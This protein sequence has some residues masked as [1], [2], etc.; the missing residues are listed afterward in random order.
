M[1]HTQIQN[2]TENVYRYHKEFGTPAKDLFLRPMPVT[3]PS[4]SICCSSKTTW[5]FLIQ[6]MTLRR[7]QESLWTFTWIQVPNAVVW[8]KRPVWS[9]DKQPHRKLWQE[10]GYIALV[11]TDGADAETVLIFLLLI[12][13]IESKEKPSDNWCEE[14]N[15]PQTRSAQAA[16]FI[17]RQQQE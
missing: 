12:D 11:H 8:V 10:S 2:C 17:Q 4:M 15:N 13:S 5:N 9:S 7:I 16:Y 6:K 3:Q 14:E 1:I